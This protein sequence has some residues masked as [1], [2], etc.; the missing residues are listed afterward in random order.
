[1]A[2]GASATAVINANAVDVVVDARVYLQ[3]AWDARAGVMRSGLI[4]VLP[5]R[6]PYG[7]APWRHPA[8][9]TVPGV[10][11]GAGLGVVTQTIVDW[12]LMELRTGVS[13]T[14]VNAA[15]PV[16][17]GRAAALLLSDGRIAGINEEAQSPERALS[18]EGVHFAMVELPRGWDVYVL[19]HHRNH[20]SAVSDRLTRGAGC[21]ADF[22]ADFR[23]ARGA[24]QVWLGAGAY[25]MAAGDVDRNGVIDAR[26]ELL[27]RAYNPSSIGVRH[28]AAPD[29]AG[30][31]GVDADLDFDGEVLSADRYFIVRNE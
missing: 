9:T 4:D 14:G 24:G 30:N 13:G 23:G 18:S 20:L 3:G 25:G 7:V 17:S 22:C 15:R 26:D 11:A 29:E 5:R 1:M 16:L 31:Y 2:N 6:Q 10:A 12:V 8:T 21:A 27:I 28:Y 19:I